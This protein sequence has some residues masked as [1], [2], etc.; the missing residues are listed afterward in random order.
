MNSVYIGDIQI[1][2][3]PANRRSRLRPIIKKL[4]R[5]PVVCNESMIVNHELMMRAIN[6]FFKDRDI[7]LYN[8]AYEVSNLKF[9]TKCQWAQ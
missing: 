4:E 3:I 5:Y 9:S 8:V 6:R 1:R 2:M 7:S